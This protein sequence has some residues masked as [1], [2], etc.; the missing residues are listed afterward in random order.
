MS[1]SYLNSE[2]CRRERETFLSEV[3]DRVA[4]GS[5]FVVYARN[6]NQATVPREFGDLIGVQFWTDDREAGTDRPLGM[7]DPMEPAYIS[8]VLRLSHD[9]KRQFD[10]LRPALKVPNSAPPRTAE[11]QDRP[12]VFVA[13]TTED[14]EEGEE[15]LKGYLSQANV[16]ILPQ[17]W[18]P[19]SD[20]ETF[21]A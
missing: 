17:T 5:V 7:P 20:R 2:W 12:Y 4:Q 6:V 10:Q 13:R 18:Y 21:E 19:Q 3:K 16:E 11:S 8:K 9:L 15:E 14:L 1:P